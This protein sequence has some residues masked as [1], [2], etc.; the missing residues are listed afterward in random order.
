[1]HKFPHL[2]FH[3]SHPHDII[4]DDDGYRVG[5]SCEVRKEKYIGRERERQREEMSDSE[6]GL[7][8]SESGTACL[9][10]RVLG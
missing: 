8:Q 3:A 5:A 10:H 2:H 6:Q 9:E 4:F 7:K 1:M